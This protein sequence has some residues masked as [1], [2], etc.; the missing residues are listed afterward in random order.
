MKTVSATLHGI[1][2]LLFL[3]FFIIPCV[4]LAKTE[5]SQISGH[6]THIETEIKS[7]SFQA[8]SDRTV[9]KK[10]ILAGDRKLGAFFTIGLIINLVMIATFV[11][12]ATGQWKKNN[13]TKK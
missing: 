11:F 2:S 9:V 4:S 7:G 3:L 13:K 10:K 5:D 8:A 6:N 1:R 12:W